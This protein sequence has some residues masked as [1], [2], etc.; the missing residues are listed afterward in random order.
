MITLVSGMWAPLEKYL[1]SSTGLAISLYLSSHFLPLSMES[2]CLY[3]GV[4][5]Q[6][7]LSCSSPCCGKSAGVG[8]GKL[9]SR[10]RE[11]LE[12]S[13]ERTSKDHALSTT[14]IGA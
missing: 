7:K 5:S 2:S 8:S 4:G 14:I 12:H 6:T 9:Q 11:G 1:R 13:L 3:E 10:S